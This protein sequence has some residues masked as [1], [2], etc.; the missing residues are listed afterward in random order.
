MNDKDMNGGEKTM[1][2][3][4]KKRIIA[5]VLC[6]VMVLSSSISALA[7]EEM[8]VDIPEASEEFSSEPMVVTETEPAGE[9][10]TETEASPEISFS[11]GDV[12]ADVETEAPVDPE[13]PAEPAPEVPEGTP[14]EEAVPE[15]PADEIPAEEE[16]F[17]DFG[18]GMS[19]SV[20]DTQ[21]LSEE[22]ELKQEFVDEAGNVVQRVTAK[23]PAG[24]FAAETSSITMEVSY[25]DADSEKYLK[26]MMNE[27]IPEGMQ[28]G[29]YV[30][31]NV[32]FKVNGEKAEALK[33]VE[34]TIEGSGL[35]ITDIKKTNVFYFDPA[36]PS[37]EGDK[38]ELKEIP[39][40]SEVLESLQSAG[41]STENIEDYDLSEITFR[42][43][44]TTDKV[45]FEG[46]KSTIYGC[47]TEEA[48]PEEVPAEPTPVPEEITPIPEE[49]APEEPGTAE[50]PETASEIEIISDEVNL[51]TEPDEEAENVIATAFMGER[52]PLLENVQ[53]EEVL[54]YKIQYTYQE[55]GET[56]ELYVRSDFA[57]V[58]D[59]SPEVTDEEDVDLTEEPGMVNELTYEDDKITV[60][61]SAAEEGIIP[62]EVSLS[63]KPITAENTE[64]QKQ[65]EEVAQHVEQKVAEEEKEVV[66]FL[67]Y[68]ISFLDAEGNK[69]EPNGEVKVS[70]NYKQAAIPETVTEEKAETTEVSVLH[71]EEDENGTVQNVVDMT[72][73][74]SAAA[75]VQTTENAEIQ[76]AEF[77]TTSF[78]V[79]TVV[80]KDHG[81]RYSRP[82]AILHFVKENGS[83]W[84]GQDDISKELGVEET[85]IKI[86]GIGN[87]NNISTSLEEIGTKYN[88]LF[89]TDKS[90]G[91]KFKAAHIDKKKGTVVTNISYNNNSGGWVYYADSKW[92]NWTSGKG[93]TDPEKDVYL[94]Y[95]EVSKGNVKEI[96]TINAPGE[97]I[98]IDLF[99]YNAKINETNA[100]QRGFK[101]HSNVKGVDGS[102]SAGKDLTYTHA[103]N[104]QIH[105][106]Y[107]KCNLRNGFPVLTN[108]ISLEY[109][110]E[111]STQNG[112]TA[113][114]NLTGLLSKDEKGYYNYD[115]SQHHAQLT[116][117]NSKLTVYN[118]R[119]SPWWNDFRYGNFLPFNKLPFDVKD[120]S[121]NSVTGGRSMTD[122]WFGMNISFSFMQPKE[123]R[124]NGEPMR[125]EFRGDDDVWVFIDGVKVLDIGGIHD[126][127]EGSIDFQ[128][129]KVSVQGFPNVSLAYLYEAA[130]K[131]QNP[132]AGN[133]DVSEYLNSIFKKVDGQYTTFKNFSAHD[134]KFFYLERG[135]G[136]ANCKLRFNIPAMDKD[137]INIS[138]E[139]ENYDEGA[140][141]D[142]EFSYELYVNGNQ[143]PEKNARYTLTHAD[144]STKILHTD[145][146]SGRFILRHGEQARF[147]QYDQGTKYYV[148]EV[149]ISS[150]TYDH[151]TIQ[152]SGVVNE[153]R[154]PIEDGKNSAQS[155]VLEV[156]THPTVTFLNRCA[157]T[158]MKHLVIKKILANGSSN[159][160]YQMKVTVGG[161]PY[162][163]KYKVGT[164]YDSAMASNEKTADE[165][166]IVTLGA[167]QVAVILGNAYSTSSED[168][169]S[170]GI[171]SGTSFKVEE[172]KPSGEY[173]T[174]EYKVD[175][176]QNSKTSNGFSG[177]GGFA[178][179][180]IE[181]Q[182]NAE[183]TVTNQQPGTVPDPDP[184][185]DVPHNK[186]IDFLGSGTNGQTN[187]TGAEYY[188]LYL[189]VKGIPNTIPEPADIVLVLDYSSSMGRKFSDATRWDYVQKSAKIAV[190]T[191]LPDNREQNNRIGIVWF[192]KNANEKNVNFTSDKSQLLNN[193]HNM[194]YDSGTNYQA[195]FWN[196]QDMLKDYGRSDSKKFV[197]FV[198]DGEPYQY[199]NNRFE[200]KPLSEGVEKAKEAAVEAA[201]LF[202]DLNG[203][204]AVSVGKDTGKVFLKDE[205]VKNVNATDKNTLI[206]SDSAA[207]T[208]AFSTILGSIT[209]QIGN[210]TIRDSL[211]EYV[212]FAS[213]AGEDLRQYD[214]DKDGVISGSNNDDTASKIGLKVN[215]SEYENA[216]VYNAHT[217]IRNAKEYQGNYTYKIDLDAKTIE[218]NFG[219][220]YFL[221]RDKVYTISFNVMLTD[222]ATQEKVNQ[223]GVKGD[224]FTDYPENNTSSEQLG[225]YS[226]KEASL[227]F[228]RVVNGAV[229]SDTKTDY[230]KPVVQPYEKADW[231]IVKVNAG[232]T[233]KLSGA[234]F[235]LT[236]NDQVLY[237]GIS[238]E[239]GFVK[240]QDSSNKP[241]TSSE[242]AKGT[243]ILQETVA[244][245][246]YA[247]SPDTWSV[248]ISAKGMKPV[249]TELKTNKPV[250]LI[251]QPDSSIYELKI[252]N[253]PIYD[254]PS[255][256]GNGIYVYMIGGVA[257]MMAAMFILY[258]MKCKGV[259]DS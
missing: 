1:K 93:Q 9:A 46:R 248:E 49:P 240:W 67:A 95:E 29:S 224:A 51:R 128:T 149:G 210:V 131:E 71:L 142:V 198:T 256:G 153:D 220:D 146:N 43:D 173:I 136:A 80:W 199:C 192:D 124:L 8:F 30:F 144:G 44:G 114:P 152:A 81:D 36:D 42:E 162:T 27:N 65:Y 172:L 79:Y 227:T 94:V 6:M 96:S 161:K 254:L 14:S 60:S 20:A 59:D 111:A 249:I 259:R 158:N 183:V 195:A 140:Y 57:K 221:E 145:E 64:T 237:T 139:I 175:K 182:H 213:E 252:E 90:T 156:G 226:N 83:S 68:D 31:F 168:G 32:Q 135:G 181:L 110:F 143:T 18:D 201:K 66:G 75:A 55:T 105:Q 186:Y 61:V 228:E 52:F 101:F 120:G 123:G 245:Q 147:D 141:S 246:G 72:A 187:L 113:Y 23:L 4:R 206:A 151:V 159:D 179:G 39:Q 138:K 257:L 154:Q 148:K 176:A 202:T 40:R 119:L 225:L 166:G 89:D 222:Q 58:V 250:D 74:E 243:Y 197:I 169:V 15:T 205:I 189:D 26:S 247:L 25:L 167:D 109:L 236:K 188:R 133:K 230:E 117:N 157:V 41:Q 212:N 191:L 217:N 63:V 251:L 204:Y 242:I 229:K 62:D 84:F 127:R 54:W 185:D 126:K 28:L 232:G 91:Y 241:V 19:D 37:V 50:E 215:I 171:P 92:N 134:F 125:F 208:E 253:T 10:F 47:Y 82:T 97:K 209:K 78:S 194:G 196:A 174:P 85:E 132:Y 184:L 214:T 207:L 99:N 116:D 45:I 34:I 137:S 86:S 244:P 21:I 35:T 87:F 107:L 177:E 38:D 150:Q 235:T 70:M 16:N 77:N 234:Q 193:I 216:D 69:V 223:N 190:N 121:D 103:Y 102:F 2:S 233:L 155:Q 56:A 164:D 129:G 130:Y 98:D 163:G 219:K 53:M 238:D 255:T 5:A 108:G 88:T 200:Q 112:V 160:K 180:V 73:E 122:V 258:K 3:N 170:R 106:D 7:G 165:N 178:S 231:Q 12:T 11:D 104:Q 24:A 76:S 17:A 211:S 203:F 33:P 48:K 13:T 100:A 118:A 218:V 115:S 22:T 239:Q